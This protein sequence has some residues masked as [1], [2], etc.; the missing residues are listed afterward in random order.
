MHFGYTCHKV[1]RMQ[2]MHVLSSH[3]LIMMVTKPYGVCVCVCVDTNCNTIPQS[4]E[5]VGLYMKTVGNQN[6]RVKLIRARKRKRK[7][8][9]VLPTESEYLHPG[10]PSLF[11]S[12]FFRL[13]PKEHDPNCNLHNLTVLM[14]DFHQVLPYQA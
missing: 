6:I 5:E 10:S 2:C 14:S 9:S 11:L 7:I 8:L 3:R 1:N 4:L 13:M 12:V